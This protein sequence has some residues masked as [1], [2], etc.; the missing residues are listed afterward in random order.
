[1]AKKR[2]P[3]RSFDDDTPRGIKPWVRLVAL[4]LAFVMLVTV[5]AGAI[6][7]GELL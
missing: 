1:M 2:K 7:A 5:L 6:T 4:S 3:T